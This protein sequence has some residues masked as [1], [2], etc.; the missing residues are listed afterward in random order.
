MA[1]TRRR[2]ARERLNLAERIGAL[3]TALALLGVAVWITINPPDH[4]VAL[5]GCAAADE[6]CIVAVDSNPATIAAALI[7]LA[8]LGLVL[9]MLGIRFTSLKAAGIELG[10]YKAETAGLP[11]VPPQPIA[12]D[13]DVLLDSEGPHSESVVTG[14]GSPTD[15]RDTAS[16]AASSQ[17]TATGADS[18]LQVEIRSGL[19]SELGVV[20]VAI[21]NLDS[22]MTA[23]QAPF[24]RDYQGAVRVSQGGWFVTHLLG[25]PTRPGQQYSVAI[26]VTPHQNAIGEVTAARFYLGRAW[27]HGVVQAMR[28]ADGHFGIMT[29]AYGPFLALCEVEFASGERI[30]LH[31]YCDFEMGPLVA[32]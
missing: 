4:T 22:M 28:G 3:I 19:G 16:G 17:P 23:E 1:P 14:S 10:A 11:E 15:Q 27:G 25:P 7:A 2:Q 5:S 32:L 13:E 6:G 24:L 8:G 30:L 9:A 29:E 31:H 20:P 12:G 26:K 21:A 18:P